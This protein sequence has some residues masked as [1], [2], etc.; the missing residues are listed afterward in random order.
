VEIRDC[1]IILDSLAASKNLSTDLSMADIVF[2][3]C[4][5]FY[6]GGPIVLVPVKMA[7]DTPAQ[8]IGRVSFRD[9]LFIISLPG[10]PAAHGEELALGLLSAPDGNIELGPP[11]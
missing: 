3:H 1:K 10:V 4:A 5:V 11:S 9:C 7:R 2:T 6:N 8:L